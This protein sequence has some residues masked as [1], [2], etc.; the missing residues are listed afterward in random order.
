MEKKPTQKKR[1][2]HAGVAKSEAG[3]AVAREVIATIS[4]GQIPHKGKIAK[5]YGYSESSIKACRPQKTLAYKEEIA[6]FEQKLIKERDRLLDAMSA[7]K[8]TNVQ[9]RD[10]SQALER[11]MKGVELLQGRATERV[12]GDK[13]LQDMFDR[14][15]D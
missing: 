4:K 10:M 15:C 3:R 14:L 12:G 1:A 2:P 13:Q 7:R 8:L 9:Y 11:T 5:K 6:S